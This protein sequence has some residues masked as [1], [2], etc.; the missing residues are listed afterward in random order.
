MPIRCCWIL[1]LA[2]KKTSERI[3]PEVLHVRTLNINITISA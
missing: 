3:R 1:Y 2:N